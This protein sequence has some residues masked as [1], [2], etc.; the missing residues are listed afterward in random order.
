MT[1]PRRCPACGAAGA[2]K[3]TA[4]KGR[5]AVFRGVTVELPSSLRLTECAA[6][7]ELLLD[8]D[9]SDAYSQAVDAAYDTELTRRAQGALAKLE[10][11]TSQRRL[12]QLL[13]LSHGYLSKVKSEAKAP[14]ATLVGQLALL[15]ADPSKRIAELEKFWSVDGAAGRT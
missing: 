8:D 11:V 1:T 3:S 9:E 14:S 10:G 6:C 13:H 5:T 4:R 12:E 7:H 2:L 15:A